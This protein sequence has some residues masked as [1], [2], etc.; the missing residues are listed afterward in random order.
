MDRVGLRVGPFEVSGPAAVPEPGSWWTARRVMAGSRDPSRVHLLV[1]PPLATPD[2]RADLARRHEILRGIDDPR[3]PTGIALYDGI[4]ALAVAAVDAA[5]LQAAVDA[6][7]DGLYEIRL[8]T[9]VDVLLE[10]AETIQAQHAHGRVHG[11]IAPC[12]VGLDAHGRVWSFGWGANVAPDPRFIAPECARGEVPGQAADQWALA[13]LGVALLTGRCPW[14]D[15]SDAKRGQIDPLLDIVRRTEPAFARV[16]GRALEHQ[17]TSR[18]PSVLP[19][20]QDLLALGR[21]TAGVSATKELGAWLVAAAFDVVDNAPTPVPPERGRIHR[22]L[23]PLANDAPSNVDPTEA[24]DGSPTGPD[25]PTQDLGH[26]LVAEVRI[27]VTDPNAHTRA[28]AAVD[29]Q[30]DEVIPELVE[31]DG[32]VTVVARRADDW[33]T[34]APRIAAVAMVAV[35]VAVMAL[36]V[37]LNW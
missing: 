15:T 4:G 37:V 9:V 10:L 2:D 33:D 13:A 11:H 20:R 14:S 34:L 1:L 35:L 27:E 29:E 23:T 31:D 25:A 26:G 32:E 3:I 16:L 6:R 8:S 21:K 36:T 30:L 5:P 22:P 18:H 7:R 19:F 28:F 12:N 17:P 24:L